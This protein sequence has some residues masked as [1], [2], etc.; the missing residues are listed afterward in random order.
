M[1]SG[2]QLAADSNAQQRRRLPGCKNIRPFNEI[3]LNAPVAS[4][5]NLAVRVLSVDGLPC[6]RD[7][8]TPE[9]PAARAIVD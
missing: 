9:I 3:A 6:K 2:I 8:A 7:P 1:L 5:L 4:I